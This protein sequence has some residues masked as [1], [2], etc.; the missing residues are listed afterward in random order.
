MD[1]KI[2][3][4][5]CVWLKIPHISR[6]W[7]IFTIYLSWIYSSSYIQP[8]YHKS[9]HLVY[10]LFIIF[11]FIFLSFVRRSR[12][13]SIQLRLKI[14]KIHILY[15]WIIYIYEDIFCASKLVNFLSIVREASVFRYNGAPLKPLN[16]IVLW[17]IEG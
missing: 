3:T 13:I 10:N 12:S 9:I 1:N 17:W 16:M 8:I 14:M 11:L 15:V 6:T 2:T 4:Y 7:W 5:S